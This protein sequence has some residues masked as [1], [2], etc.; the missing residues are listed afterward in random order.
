MRFLW[1]ELAHHRRKS[2]VVGAALWANT[3]C[4]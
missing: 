4:C 1:Q 3:H 2:R